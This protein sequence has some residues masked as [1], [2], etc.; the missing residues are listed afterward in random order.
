M[1][2]LTQ[3]EQEFYQDF[4]TTTSDDSEFK[5]EMEFGELL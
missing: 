1:N 3:E 5:V 2:Y 4:L